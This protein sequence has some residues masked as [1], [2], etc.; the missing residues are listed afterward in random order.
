MRLKPDMYLCNGSNASTHGHAIQQ[1]RRRRF[2]RSSPSSA[3]DP[4][5][6]PPLVRL[7]PP[8][9][10]HSPSS[11]PPSATVERVLSL[12]ITSIHRWRL[13]LPSTAAAHYTTRHNLLE[14]LTH[15]ERDRLQFG[16]LEVGA[17]PTRKGLRR[18]IGRWLTSHKTRSRSSMPD[19]CVTCKS[20][21]RSS[22]RSWRVAAAAA[23]T[24]LPL[25]PRQQPQ[26]PAR[27]GAPVSPDGS[28][29][30]LGKRVRQAIRRP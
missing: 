27:S 28:R 12:R 15:L 25:R 3:S 18:K 4:A 24:G 11:S 22:L 5:S 16:Q 13:S 17:Q 26:R 23:A 21:S 30:R 9:P 2:T 1:L 7:P 10:P 20:R 8:P 29:H 6:P 19:S 14:L